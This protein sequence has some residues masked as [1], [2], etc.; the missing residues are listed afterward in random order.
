VVEFHSRNV[1]NLSVAVLK[2]QLASNTGINP[3]T[4]TRFQAFID[5]WYDDLIPRL[6]AE[7]HD[8]REDDMHWNPFE[9][10][11]AKSWNA[12][13][14]AKYIREICLEMEGRSNPNHFY[15]NCFVKA[16]EQYEVTSADELVKDG[17]YTGSERTRLVMPPSQHLTGLFCIFQSLFF[18]ALKKT[19]PGFVQAM[20]TE[21][22][23]EQMNAAIESGLD[24]TISTDGSGFD[25]T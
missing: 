11:Q 9:V 19:I 15:F 3:Q 7:L 10:V 25:S 23:E 24:M 21:A 17:Y 6:R 5:E 20:K 2:R 16:G 8:Q 18:N 22:L 1:G 13:K 14:K 4:K 12:G